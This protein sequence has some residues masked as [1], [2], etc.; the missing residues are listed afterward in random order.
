M[1]ELKKRIEK[2]LTVLDPINENSTLKER[3]DAFQV[4]K[5]TIDL[6]YE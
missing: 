1:D 2:A 5:E 4:L 6:I 3:L